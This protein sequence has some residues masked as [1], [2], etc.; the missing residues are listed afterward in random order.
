MTQKE[1]TNW[2]ASTVRNCT[3][4][5]QTGILKQDLKSTKKNIYGEGRSNFSTHVIEEGHEMKNID[6]IMTILKKKATMKKSI[7]SKK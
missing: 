2:R 5:E 6:D 3:L 7:N 1:Y 4:E